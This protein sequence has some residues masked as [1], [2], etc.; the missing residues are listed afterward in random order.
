MKKIEGL[1]RSLSKNEMKKIN[2]GGS[3]QSYVG[4]T[5]FV[6]ETSAQAQ[7]SVAGGGQWCCTSCCSASWSSKVGCPPL[8]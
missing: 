3:C 4:G 7:Q 2:A 8:P 5:L 1:G 6:A